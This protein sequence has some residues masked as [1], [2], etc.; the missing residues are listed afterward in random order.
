MLLTGHIRLIDMDMSKVLSG[1]TFTMCGTPEY[2]SVEVVKGKGYG[3]GADWWALGV[4]CYE[5]IS[6]ETP[7]RGDNCYQ[8][9]KNI[10]S[11]KVK[12]GKAVD[13]GSKM[14]I[15]DLLVEGEA[16]RLGVLGG[17]SAL[18]SHPYFKGVD[19]FAA[20]R[21]LLVPPLQTSAGIEEGMYV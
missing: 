18:K 19:W 5:M 12:Y 10:E 9:Y 15:K 20:E 13:K 21:E 2:L 11:K 4:L 6:G 1:P 7:F 3:V 17:G 8:T 14:F 16:R